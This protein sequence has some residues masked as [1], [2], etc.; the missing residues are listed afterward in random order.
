MKTR[1]EGGLSNLPS[2]GLGGN[3]DQVG[4]KRNAEILAR[5]LLKK[6]SRKAIAR[7]KAKQ[8]QRAGAIKG[9]Q[10]SATRAKDRR[11][12]ILEAGRKRIRSTKLPMGGQ[13]ATAG[14]FY[15]ALARE[16]N[17]PA[18]YVRL[19]IIEDSPGFAKAYKK[20]IRDARKASAAR[21]RSGV[22]RTPV[23]S[24]SSAPTEPRIRVSR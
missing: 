18:A 16:L 23:E 17:E 20:F 24:V 6:P 1:M 2:F 3:S 9:G 15:K 12:R 11:R 21:S 13:P 5:A 22:S 8:R 10:V 14:D 7:A 4:T 19:A